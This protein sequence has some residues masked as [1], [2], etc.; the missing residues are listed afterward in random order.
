MIVREQFE[1]ANVHAANNWSPVL[2]RPPRSSA[3][4]TENQS[5]SS[6]ANWVGDRVQIVKADVGKALRVQQL[7]GYELGRNADDWS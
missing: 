3:A 2:R 1:A 5:T 7:L 6:R 4:R